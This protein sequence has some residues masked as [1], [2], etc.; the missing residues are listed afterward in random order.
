MKNE[1]LSTDMKTAIKNIHDEV[2]QLRSAFDQLKTGLYDV[3]VKQ[4]QLQIGQDRMWARQKQMQ[5]QQDKLQY[6]LREVLGLPRTRLT[7][8]TNNVLGSWV[9]WEGNWDAPT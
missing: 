5:I 6:D 3:Q 9:L 2:G 4:E 1:A 8:P 7:D